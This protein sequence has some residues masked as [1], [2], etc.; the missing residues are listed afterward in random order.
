MNASKIKNSNMVKTNDN[1]ASKFMFPNSI[2]VDR[3]S[4]YRKMNVRSSVISNHSNLMKEKSNSYTVLYKKKSFEYAQIQEFAKRLDSLK[5]EVGYGKNQIEIKNTVRSRKNELEIIYSPENSPL[6]REK[7]LLKLEKVVNFDFFSQMSEQKYNE[8]NYFADKSISDYSPKNF[9]K[10]LES[11][12]KLNRGSTNNFSPILEAR[13]NLEKSEKLSFSV[14]LRQIIPS[15]QQPK[16]V[17]DGSYFENKDGISYDKNKIVRKFSLNNP[18]LFLAKKYFLYQL[19]KV[20]L[21]TKKLLFFADMNEK[22]NFDNSNK[23]KITPSYEE[24]FTN[25]SQINSTFVQE[26]LTYADRGVQY[27]NYYIDKNKILGRGGFSTVYVG[28]NLND[29]KEYAIKITDKRAKANKGKTKYQYVQDEVSILKRIYSKYVVK[30]IEVL[31]TK[32]ECLIVME[33][34]RNSALLSKINKLDNFKVWKY[35]RHLL[36][37][38]EHCHEIAKIVHRD[39]NVNNLLIS[40]DD[41]LKLTDFGISVAITDES[42][43]IPC[44]LGPSTLT[45]PEAKESDVT[46]YYGKPADMW[47]CGVTLYHMIYKTPLFTPNKLIFNFN[48]VNE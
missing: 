19:K 42:D 5:P 23:S 22:E 21:Q 6:S 2:Q 10:Q 44:N 35:F 37:G 40:E 32:T 8:N 46:H 47:L 29:H 36:V 28:I 38:L 31:E 1:E 3:T 14:F 34:M 39:I 48:S 16:G 9:S 15:K 13:E 7:P 43:L 11:I 18:N 33:Y 4:T 20:L 17:L 41:I 26:V 27:N 25:V 45:P 30:T 12:K 24:I